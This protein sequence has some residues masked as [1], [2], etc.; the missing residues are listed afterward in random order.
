MSLS[1]KSV[2]DKILINESQLSGQLNESIHSE[3]RSDFSLML[4]M[5][6]DDVRLHSQFYLP[7]TENEPNIISDEQLRKTYHLPKKPLLAHN[8]NNTLS[9]FNQAELIANQ[10]L[11]DIYLQN[12]LTPNP[13]AFR[14]D[15]NHIPKNVLDNCSLY[16]QKK[17]DE[18]KHQPKDKAKNN[19]FNNRLSFDAKA[20]LDNIQTSLVKAP[21]VNV[22]SSA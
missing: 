2:E 20:W 5:L 17:H 1:V 16:C 22:H 19:L 10:Q 12:S 11:T 4:A 18:Q 14:D 13:L 15:V 3:R 7:V 21:M 8:I 6:T 9:C